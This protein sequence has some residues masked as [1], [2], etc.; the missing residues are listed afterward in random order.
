MDISSGPSG[1][2]MIIGMDQ[3]GE[4]NMGLWKYVQRQRKHARG[5]YWYRLNGEGARGLA[6]GKDGHPYVVAAD[7]KSAWPT[8]P[9]ESGEKRIHYFTSK[10]ALNWNDAK[11]YCEK[12]GWH[13]AA[14]FTENENYKFTKDQDVQKRNEVWIGGRNYPVK[15]RKY[16]LWRWSHNHRHFSFKNWASNKPSSSGDCLALKK[17]GR[18]N[19][20]DCKQ[21][22]TFICRSFKAMPKVMAAWK[23]RATQCKNYNQDFMSKN[24]KKVN[25]IRFRL[26]NNVKA[27][28]IAATSAKL[29]HVAAK[30]GSVYRH[31]IRTEH[32]EQKNVWRAIGGGL[33]GAV[34]VANGKD[35]NPWAVTD[36]GTVWSF[37]SKKWVQVKGTFGAIADVAVG[38]EGH[39][40]LV[41]KNGKIY[42]HNSKGAWAAFPSPAAAKITVEANGNPIIL[43]KDGKIHRGEK[44]HGGR[45]MT[46]QGSNF[47]DIAV[48]AEG[49]LIA[50]K[51]NGNLVKAD[52]KKWVQVY[53]AAD[54]N[55]RFG[56]STAASVGAGGQIFRVNA[57]N[58]VY[59]PRDVCEFTP[60]S[61]ANTCPWT[62]WIKKGKKTW[63]AARRD[64]RKAG[65]DLASA[66]T[67]RQFSVMGTRLRNM[68]KLRVW[69]GHNDLEKNGTW[70]WSDKK[71]M[72]KKGAYKILNSHWM[73]NLP[74]TLKDKDCGTAVGNGNATKR[75]ITAFGHNYCGKKMPFMCMKLK[76]AKPSLPLKN[77]CKSKT[78]DKFQYKFFAAKKTWADARNACASQ[79]GG[80]LVSI[81][82]YCEQHEVSKVAGNSAQ[83]WI[84]ANARNLKGEW[85]WSDATQKNG[86]HWKF[87][88]AGQPQVVTQ[89][90]KEMCGALHKSAA[91][92]RWHDYSC[93]DKKS[94]VCKRS[95]DFKAKNPKSEFL[96]RR[97]KQSWN[98]ARNVCRS[99][100]GDLA[101]INSWS[102]QRIAYRLVA[103]N[104]VGRGH[105][106]VGRAWIGLKA[107]K[108]DW[109]TAS[110][111]KMAWNWFGSSAK[112]EGCAEIYTPNARGKWNN[113][114]C[115]AKAAYI[116]K[117]KVGAKARS[118]AW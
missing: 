95:V 55:S 88:A 103:E 51:K 41:G 49:S 96:L 56:K 21:E 111:N 68:K 8:K 113:R 37:D 59:W 44:T 94:F 50:T 13:L 20:I 85:N 102:E 2:L 90:Q 67:M 53:D 4:K 118:S 78:T 116:C 28:H 47:I 39:V 27:V 3:A 99:W 23:R 18:W 81:H 117:R 66:T 14:A 61:D 33:E 101:T 70:R 48:G 93:N 38:S 109:R 98:Q 52:H 30:N 24:V 97:D 31:G 1:D 91:G 45:W 83:T 80:E 9:C 42:H 17:N 79:Y 110:G 82:N 34:R 58:N 105:S 112:S 6:V 108:N 114:N 25:Q 115:D 73:T 43:G 75:T 84:G 19:N 87:W 92:H 32:G 107:S 64:C 15:G 10:F 65:G 62:F 106:R 54:K 72:N 40:Y 29:I 11:A 69:V 74:N 71:I 89:N 22:R 60:P 77:E 12:Q 35:G 57:A 26:R 104:Q 100:G 46:M 5:N 36:S 63:H 16:K 86:I 7:G 76:G